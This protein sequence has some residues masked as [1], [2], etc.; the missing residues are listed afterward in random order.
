MRTGLHILAVG[1]AIV[2]MPTV[3]GCQNNTGGGGGGSVTA[4]FELG[5]GLDEFQMEAGEPSENRG[6]GTFDI[7]G[8]TVKSGTVQ[9][10]PDAVTVTPADAGPEK[11][12]VSMADGG[13]FNLTVTVW[14]AAVDELTTV[15]GGGE[16]YGPFEIA[17][18]GNYVPVSIE[19]SEVTL[20][21]TTADLINAGEISIWHPCGGRLRRDDQYFPLAFSA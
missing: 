1:L 18:D 17:L 11:A 10:D 21:Q 8:L 9:L 20:T 14:I 19:P 5:E 2:A 15:C 7:S 13:A 3:V 4:D 12:G 6:T 16:Q